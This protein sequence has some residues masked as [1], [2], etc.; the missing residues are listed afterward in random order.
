MEYFLKS[1]GNNIFLFWKL[2]KI[3]FLI[4]LYTLMYLWREIER[5]RNSEAK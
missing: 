3:P 2:I 1:F 4:I 5:H